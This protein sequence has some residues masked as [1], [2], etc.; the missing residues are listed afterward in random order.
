MEDLIDNYQSSE[1]P[2]FGPERFYSDRLKWW[3]FGMLLLA[4]LFK[5][6]HWPGGGVMMAMTG[7]FAVVTGIAQLFEGNKHGNWIKALFGASISVS[8]LYFVFRFQLWPGAN[9][10]LLAAVLLAAGAFVFAAKSKSKVKVNRLTFILLGLCISLWRFPD[11]SVF[12]MTNMS[13]VLNER[14]HYNSSYCWGRYGD[15]LKREG[16]ESEAAMAYAKYMDCL[17]RE[18]PDDPD[19]QALGREL[20]DLMKGNRN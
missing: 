3:L 16:K 11:S 6:R 14:E 2:R 9:F 12:Y 8:V 13:K 10:V 15:L 7:V 18:N 1:T 17:S 19:M 20:D 5:N 4:F